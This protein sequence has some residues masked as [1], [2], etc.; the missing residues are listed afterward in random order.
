MVARRVVHAVSRPAKAI[1][2][3]EYIISMRHQQMRQTSGMYQKAEPHGKSQRYV[4]LTDIHHN[5]AL[6]SHYLIN[7]PTRRPLPSG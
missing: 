7:T 5:R 1:R 2:N 6:V 4:L 3:P